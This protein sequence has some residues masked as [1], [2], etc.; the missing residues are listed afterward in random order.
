MPWSHPHNA[1]GDFLL[2]RMC[3]RSRLILSSVMPVMQMGTA[4]FK[5]RLSRHTSRFECVSEDI[6]R[7][8]SPLLLP[9]RF[10]H[11]AFAF[12]PPTFFEGCGEGKWEGVYMFCV[13][14]PSQLEMTQ[15]VPVALGIESRIRSDVLILFRCDWNGSDACSRRC[16]WTMRPSEAR[17]M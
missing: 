8:V 3:S 10:C 12:L 16:Y 17:K 9:F 7:D 2:C 14:G 6:G 13:C 1:F 15:S 5:F 4:F 11:S